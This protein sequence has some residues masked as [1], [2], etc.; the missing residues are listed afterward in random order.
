MGIHPNQRRR[1]QAARLRA[2]GL[3]FE[4]IGQRLGVT[5]QC[6]YALVWRHAGGEPCPKAPIRCRE[7]RAE[8]NAKAASWRDNLKALCVPC[9]A[10]KPLG[11]RLRARRIAAGLL[12][13]ELSRRAGLKQG[14]V[15][16]IEHGRSGGAPATAEKLARVLGGL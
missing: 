7:C 6:A 16:A 12:I 2:E 5:K 3:S 15:T 11:E 4:A 8:L 13:K 10:G 1:A 9:S 14:P